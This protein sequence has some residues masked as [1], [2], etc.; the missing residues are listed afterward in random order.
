MPSSVLE[1][2]KMGIWDYEPTDT[3][4][5]SFDSTNALPGT[6]EKLDILAARL[7]KGLPLWHPSDRRTFDDNEA[8]RS[9]SL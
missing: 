2:I 1:A 5:N 6:S 7:E 8:T 3:A 4:S 9:F